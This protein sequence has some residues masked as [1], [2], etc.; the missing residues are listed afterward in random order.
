MTFWVGL[1]EYWSLKRE[2]YGNRSV[3]DWESTIALTISLS[4]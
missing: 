4:S 1:L 2:G 3:E